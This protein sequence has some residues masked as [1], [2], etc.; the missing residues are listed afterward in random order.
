MKRAQIEDY[1]GLTSWA[2]P[3]EGIGGLLKCRV[4]DFRVEET[5]KVPALDEK[6]RFT[7]A[8]VTM[9]NWESN[10]YLR[11]LAR[12]C[13]IN[14][15]RIF[16]SGIK[17]KRAITTQILVID[18][19][20]R[21]VEQVEIPDS[22]I[23]VLGRTHQK[24]AMGDH[25][26]NRFTI[27]VRGCCDSSGNPIDAKEAMMRVQ[28]IREGFS[29]SIGADAFPNWIGP[30]RFGST[31][32]VTPM[33][34]MAVIDGDFEKAVDLYVGMEGSRESDDSEA[35]RSSWREWKDPPR[36]LELAPERL[37]YESSMIKHLVEK[38][39]DYLGAFKTLPKSLQLLM[40]HSA[41]SLAFNHSLSGR[42][43]SGLSI[44]EPSEGD[45]V[46][47]LQPNG[48]IDVGKMSYVTETNLD[49]C[50]RNCSLGRLV[51]T[52][53]LPGRDAEYAIGD[54]GKIE[55]AGIEK[56][57]LYKVEWLVR[58]IPRLTSSGTRRPLSVPF[59]DIS[60]EQ[61]TESSS[62]SQ[63]WEEGPMD[64]DRWHPEG[65]CLRLRFTLPAGTYAT[66]LMRE[67]MRSPLDHY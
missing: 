8:R 67:L 22:S 39:G 4:E 18:A 15:N 35:F 25:D 44:I 13:G 48:R 61:T 23:E 49:R 21:K 19:Q 27:T 64:G 47:P 12:S 40:V 66:V 31:R 29:D 14:R 28:K 63:R 55:V 20:R 24:V 56:A 59:R 1:L 9:T 36:S 33:V 41:Q 53:T 17:D 52:G 46:A 34:G 2:V 7:V 38:P 43:K 26:G 30:Q 16:S 58:E 3:G 50:R 62:L 37:G 42:I 51:V 57:G 65:A 60:V 45:L 11:R 6:G 10:R 54:P 5:S 32:P